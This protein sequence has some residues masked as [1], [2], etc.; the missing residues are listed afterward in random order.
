MLVIH[1]LGMMRSDTRISTSMWWLTRWGSRML[2]NTPRKGAA[3]GLSRKLSAPPSPL[4]PEEAETSFFYSVAD[5]GCLSRI[6]EF[7]I[8]DPELKYFNSTNCLEAR[9]PRL[10]RHRIPDDPQ[11]WIFKKS[12]HWNI[13]NNWSSVFI[14]L[15][16]IWS[17]KIWREFFYKISAQIPTYVLR[18]K[19]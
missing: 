10:K 7:S 5:P 3:S 14:A 12:V 1:E 8:P 6:P 9:I 16:Q 13:Q 18:V 17:Q 2:R 15:T 11:H 4:L 19:I